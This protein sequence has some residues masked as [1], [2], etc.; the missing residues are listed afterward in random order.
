MHGS[1]LLQDRFIEASAGTGKTYAIEQ[2]VKRLVLEAKVPFQEILVLSFTQAATL[3]LQERIRSLLHRSGCVDLGEESIYTLHGFCHTMLTRFALEAQFPLT[4]EEI[5][6]GSMMNPVRECMQDGLSFLHPLQIARLWSHV[7]QDGE[8]LV[9]TLVRL[10]AMDVPIRRGKSFQ[11]LDDLFHQSKPTN[12]ERWLEELREI[13]PAYAKTCTRQRQLK[14]EI[15]TALYALTEGDW[16][17]TLPLFDPSHRLLRKQPLPC[18][19]LAWIEKV[20]PQLK[21]AWDPFAILAY[22]AEEIR[23]RVMPQLAQ[24]D[25]FSFQH[26]IHHMGRCVDQPVFAEKIR[27]LFRVVI[28]DEFQDTDP[29]QWHIFRTL[30][31]HKTPIYL[32]GDPKQ[33]IYRFRQADIYTYLQ[34][35]EELRHTESLTVNY[36]SGASLLHELNRLFAG[37][38]FPLPRLHRELPYE[39]V[40][41]G[42]GERA[43]DP[44]IV[45]LQA[46]DEAS[47]FQH[48]I[49][50]IQAHPHA[51]VAV[52][53]KDRYQA[54]RFAQ[55]APFPVKL[56]RARSLIDSPALP[57]LQ[58]L[59]EVLENPFHDAGQRLLA[60]RLQGLAVSTLWGWHRQAQEEDLFTVIWSIRNQ[61]G[62]L[63]FSQPGGELL[64]HDLMQW[65]EVLADRTERSPRE[66]LALLMQEESQFPTLKGYTLAEQARVEVMTTHVSKGLEFDLVFPIGLAFAQPPHRDLVCVEGSLSYREEDWANQKVELEAEQV[67]QVYVACTRAKKRLYLPVVEGENSPL[68][69]VIQGKEFP[70]DTDTPLATPSLPIA[71]WVEPPETHPPAVTEPIVS[72]TSLH[73]GRPP[74]CRSTPP[75]PRW[76]LPAGT[77]VGIWFHHVLEYMDFSQVEQSSIHLVQQSALS[78]YQEEVVSLLRVMS[79]T[80]FPSGFCLSD[81]PKKQMWRE[82]P[83][84]FPYETGFCKGVIDL[85]FEYE[86]CLYLV[87]W[88][89]NECR[90]SIEE[91][92]EC[93]GYRFQAQLYQEA[94]QRWMAV[95]G[96]D[97]PI[98]TFY[99]FFRYGEE[100]L[101]PLT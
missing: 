69:A 47:L 72:F 6:E 49:R 40:S 1:E 19:T 7:R 14:P 39:A 43:L 90:G 5:S 20:V 48:V 80:P 75:T 28:I 29:Q 68:Q 76:N 56:R 81:V 17:K 59:L 100:G 91:E 38:T 62:P 89:S 64:Y 25:R 85:V 16:F 52:L 61:L 66:R 82:M 86:G 73:S 55:V 34:A 71:N 22:T 63:L 35:K 13:A 33:A 97:L 83:F 79:H 36:R 41:A 74:L 15:E 10:L 32:V 30:F 94:L 92:I 4:A 98:R 9:G 37:L 2:Y 26:L 12:R 88:K 77:E 95:I 8:A 50:A 78:S 21:E 84:L 96:L 27:S 58:D 44:P 53:I 45:M 93:H 46:Q 3:E 87:D 60:G 24:Q 42:S 57:F 54:H 18:E 65:A 101:V 23:Q 99:F 31:L 70:C 11:E 67:R 51:S